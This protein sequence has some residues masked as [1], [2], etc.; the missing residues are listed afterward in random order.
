MI[1][2]K[3]LFQCFSF[4]VVSSFLLT[5][6][7]DTA[8]TDKMTSEIIQNDLSS[9]RST[10]VAKKIQS[11]A[12]Y[13]KSLATFTKGSSDIKLD[14]LVALAGKKVTLVVLYEGTAPWASVFNSG[15]VTKTGNESFNAL[16]DSYNMSITKQF[17]IDDETEGLSIEPNMLLDNPT[18]AAKEISMIDYVLMVQVKE[19][20]TEEKAP[21]TSMK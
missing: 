6:C 7:S 4:V 16:L 11:K 19:V 15:N 12:Y 10:K 20:P 3:Y 21:I 9:T 14:K 13:Y 8:N 2:L 17:E 5:S 1:N 18:E